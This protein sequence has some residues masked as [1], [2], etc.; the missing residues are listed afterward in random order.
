MDAAKLYE[1]L[2]RNQGNV[3][4]PEL[5]HG[6]AQAILK[7]DPPPEDRTLRGQFALHPEEYNGLWF[8]SMDVVEALKHGLAALH[9]A[10]W[11]E[12]EGFRH[13]EGC[14][15]DYENY[16]R[17]EHRGSF[18]LFTVCDPEQDWKV[19]GDAMVMVSR[20]RHTQKLSS[21]E[22]AFYL[23][24]EARK[25]WTALRF[26]RYVERCLVKIGVTQI[27]WGCKMSNDISALYERAGYTQTA[28]V[29]TKV[30]THDQPA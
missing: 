19:V 3:L 26:I 5:A 24:P 17:L 25:G 12:T 14:N 6:L 13:S 27:A 16:M 23:A 30:I 15:V 4:T 7:L 21:W 1:L 29:F 10:H 2:G 11:Q 8:S 18:I 28:K 22:D 20:N 9:E